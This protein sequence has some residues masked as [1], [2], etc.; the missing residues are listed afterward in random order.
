M[1]QAMAGGAAGAQGAVAAPPPLPGGA[2]AVQFYA[3]IDG[4]QAGPFDLN[5]IRQQAATGRI[6]RQTLVWRPGMSS[7]TPA[8]DVADLAN[9]VGGTP[10]PLPK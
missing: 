1:G 3:A 5:A 4:Q 7:W 8:G 10:P 2:A 6:S 9:V